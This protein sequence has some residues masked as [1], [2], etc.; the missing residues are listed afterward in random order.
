MSTEEII[1]DS[2][3]RL[4]SGADLLDIAKYL[5]ELKVET[6]K[7]TEIINLLQ[8]Y[9]QKSKL[10][11]FY[12]L[13]TITK[14]ILLAPI[15]IYGFYLIYTFQFKIRLVIFPLILGFAC[16][17]IVIIELAKL[18]KQIKN[19]F[20]ERNQLKAFSKKID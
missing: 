20:N 9:L 13:I 11:K 19:K 14:I 18:F 3:K 8:E 4:R 7:K 10:D 16:G 2:K 6:D 17:I 12:I 5:D 1:E 15:S